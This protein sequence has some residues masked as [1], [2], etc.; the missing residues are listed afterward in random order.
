MMITTTL[1][2]AVLTLASPPVLP[3]PPAEEPAREAEPTLDELVADAP[4]EIREYVK[5]AK[6]EQLSRLNA[7]KAVIGLLEHDLKL[8]RAG[9][10][11]T[12]DP[13][14]PAVNFI[15]TDDGPSRYEFGSREF[16]E[17]A[18]RASRG[19]IE[20]AEDDARYYARTDIFVHPV[21]ERFEIG[22]MGRLRIDD[23]HRYQVRQ[24]F[25]ASNALI[26][27]EYR[28]EGMYYLGRGDRNRISSYGPDLE[29][30]P[31]ATIWIEGIEA[32]RLRD[33]R[34]FDPAGYAFLIDRHRT[35]ET[36][37]GGSNTVLNFRPLNLGKY[38]PAKRLE[39]SRERR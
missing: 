22:S 37:E 23:Y 17:E 13:P 3:P 9:R 14:P 28:N 6:Q 10:I 35:Y 33:G 30:K 39:G 16:K 27:C 25:D 2:A 32:E 15:T 7:A 1:L 12:G 18:I 26:T 34:D 36:A 38:L 11:V 8:R 5:A 24:V 4:A 19:A 20:M 29:W 21:I 31:E